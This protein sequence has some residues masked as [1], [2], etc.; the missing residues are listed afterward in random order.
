[1]SDTDDSNRRRPLKN[2]PPDGFQ[3]KI[4]L[5]WIIG[6]FALTALLYYSG[7]GRTQP[8]ATLNMYEVVELAEKGEVTKGQIRLDTSAGSLNWSIVKGEVK[9]PTLKSDAG[10]TKLCGR[11]L[12]RGLVDFAQSPRLSWRN[13][14]GCPRVSAT[15]LEK[16]SS[17]PTHAQHDDGTSASIRTSTTRR[18]SEV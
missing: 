6:I 9:E 10:P 1:M 18:F 15:K 14:S 13:P 16:S 12:V 8:T 4:I 3:P 2:L 5:F 17:S 7:S 11:G